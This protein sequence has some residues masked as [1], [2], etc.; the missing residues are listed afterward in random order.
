MTDTIDPYTDETCCT[1]VV[2]G[3]HRVAFSCP[4]VCRDENCKLEYEIE[5]DFHKAM[6]EVK[7]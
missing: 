1:C 2:C 3:G 6:G 5:C 4:P 7:P